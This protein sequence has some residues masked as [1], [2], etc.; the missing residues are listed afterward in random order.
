[1]ANAARSCARVSI[2]LAAGIAAIALMPSPTAT[3]SSPSATPQGGGRGRGPAP[4]MV[5]EPPPP[6]PVGSGALS[7]VITDASTGRP[8]S[9]ALVGLFSSPAD[10]LRPRQVTDEAGQFL[11]RDLPP[12]DY[13]LSA[14]HPDYLSAGFNAAPGESAARIVLEEAQW[15]P[16]ANIR[17]SRPASLSGTVLDERG[18]PIV[19][20]PVRIL[21]AVEI[22][23]TRRWARGPVAETDDRGMYRVADLR[24]GTYIVHVPSVQITLAD[25]A[26]RP[27]TPP[28]RPLAMARQGGVGT[29]V[30]HFP[31]SGVPGRG[32]PMAYHP[33]ARST[34][35]AVPIAL[36]SGEA[37]SGVDVHMALATT[38]RVSGALRGP[39]DADRQ[40]PRVAR[41]RGGRDVRPGG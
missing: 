26:V 2:C 31:T 9:G 3:S 33:A 22:A 25:G 7:G 37:R 17:L 32:Y 36:E 28:Q 24:P 39:P 19:G 20:V 6:L 14:A 29:I 30:G 10:R 15:V 27:P 18:E 23:G 41:A 38:V 21:T 8:I 40:P 13:G 1:M 11:F 16:D 34:S 4:V 12:A 35:E 5:I